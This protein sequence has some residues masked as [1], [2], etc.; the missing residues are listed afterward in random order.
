MR[1]GGR[2]DGCLVERV[3]TLKADFGVGLSKSYLL[4]PELD[5]VD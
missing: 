5:V 4:S 1:R 2:R 3:A